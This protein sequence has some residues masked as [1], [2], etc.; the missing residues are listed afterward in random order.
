MFSYYQ[1]Q[2]S[3]FFTLALSSLV[4]HLKSQVGVEEIQ[5]KA[6]NYLASTLFFS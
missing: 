1:I 5:G 6:I 4:N 2:Q 3:L